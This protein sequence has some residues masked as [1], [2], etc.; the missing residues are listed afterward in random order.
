MSKGVF[1]LVIILLGVVTTYF[2]YIVCMLKLPLA[3][4]IVS[5]T[6]F[7][8]AMLIQLLFTTVKDDE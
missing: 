2:N 8:E 4:E 1:F 3:V 7:I 5:I 6:P